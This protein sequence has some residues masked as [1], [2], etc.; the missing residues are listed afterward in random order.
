MSDWAIEALAR[1]HVRDVFDC[2]EPVLSE[3]LRRYA[4]Q[5]EDRGLTRTYV[6]VRG[7]DPHVLGYYTLRMGAVEADAFPAQEARRL[8][9]YPVPVVH[10]ARLAVDT[11]VKGQGIGQALLASALKKACLAAD[12]I[13]A[14]A[15]EVVAKTPEAKRFYEK[16]GFRRLE[17]D[18]LHLYLPI[19]TARRAQP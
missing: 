14:F 2:G 4:R 17:D 12:S 16:F 1:R 3:F 18:A 6:A 15:V 19:A 5:N 11:S 8:P 10:I 9:R 7:G 13:G